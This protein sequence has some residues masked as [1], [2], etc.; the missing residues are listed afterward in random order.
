MKKYIFC[1]FSAAMALTATAATTDG[2]SATTDGLSAD[3]ALARVVTQWNSHRAAHRAPATAEAFRLAATGTATSPSGTGYYIFDCAQGGYVVA[4]ASAAQ[5]AI[6]AYMDRGK[7]QPEAMPGAFHAWLDE[8]SRYGASSEARVAAHTTAR[9]AGG[10][11]DFLLGDIA[12]TQDFPMNMNCPVYNYDGYNYPTYAGCVAIA[13]G[14]IMRYYSYPQQGTGSIAYKTDSYNLDVRTNLGDHSY[15][16]AHILPNYIYTSPTSADNAEVARFV[17]DVAASVQMD[18]TPA[19]SNSQDFRAAKALKEN[20]GYDRSLQL[21]DH[22][23]YST[24]EWADVMRREIDARRPVYVSGAN[25]QNNQ[26]AGHAFVVDGY[27]AEGYFH[28]NWGWNGSS[29][30]YYLLTDLTPKD[31]QGAGGSAG[32]YAFMQN[33]IV[34]IQP[35]QGGAEAPAMLSLF[36]EQIWTERDANGD[37]IHFQICNPSATDFQGLVALRITDNDG[38]TLNDPAATALKTACKAGFGGE[39]AWY[40]DLKSLGNR[41]GMRFEIIYQRDGESEWLVAGSR[42]GSPHSLVTYR[43]AG[44]SIALQPNPAETFRM[45][46]ADLKA[47]TPLKPSA[48]ASFT[49]RVKNESDYEYFAPLY[50]M[51]YDADGSALIGYTDYQLNLVPAHGEATVKFDY[52]LPADEGDYHFCVAYETLGYN[53][54]YSPM[55]REGEGAYDYV[56]SVT[57]NPGGENPGGGGENPGGGDETEIDGSTLSYVMECVDYGFDAVRRDVKVRFEGDKVFIQG[58][59]EE[60]PDAWAVATLGDAVAEFD[61]PQYLGEWTYNGRTRKQYLTGAD[62]NTGGVSGLTLYYDADARSFTSFANNWIF[63]TPTPGEMNANYDHLYN[64]VSIIPANQAGDEPTITPP[65]GLA[66][67]V[68]QLKGRNPYSG[69][70]TDYLVNVGTTGSDF[71]IQGL[72]PAFPNAWVKGSIKGDLAT[73]KTPQYIGNYHGLYNMYVAAVDPATEE[74]STLVMHYDAAART[75]TLNGDTGFFIVQAGETNIMPMMLLDEVSIAPYKAPALDYSELQMPQDKADAA[76]S[77]S[78]SGINADDNSVVN[79][80]VSVVVDGHDVYVQGLSTYFPDV[81]VKGRLDDTLAIFERNQHMGAMQGYDIWL[82][83][84][85]A[86]SGELL[87]GNF[88]LQYNPATGEFVQPEVNYLAINA[89]TT[90]VYHLELYKGV[91]LT[92]SGVDG[93]KAATAARRAPFPIYDLSGRHTGAARKGIVIEN[94]RKQVR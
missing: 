10:Q 47:E 1:L 70:P 16:W 87:Y 63:L 37:A 79:H 46:L 19:A 31:K 76:R 30:G 71:Y 35:D 48:T 34:G 39:R 27:N 67:S 84:G 20:F 3:A 68:C 36:Y 11:E 54:D 78:F 22:S 77:Y 13:M 32:G 55:L 21:I 89:S 44:G 94:G 74:L 6:L 93:L 81:W 73:F 38:L 18:F 65:D 9:N 4:S 86:M 42:T 69:I 29:N 49:A 17:Y 72:Y 83:G 26:V 61:T 25:V 14:Q 12:W 53:Y 57:K 82:G 8:M 24:A 7:Y 23:Y 62:T 88:I 66:T 80:D 41:V 60:V 40:I 51:V 56:F 64:S 58:I 90:K 50:L 33:A 75:F 91:H 2:L 92:P 5:P 28:V 52:E 15:D 59:S 85:D 43:T 45:R